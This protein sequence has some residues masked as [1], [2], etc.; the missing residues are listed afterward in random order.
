[1]K[2]Y[3]N[4]C[5]NNSAWACMYRSD[6]NECTRDCKHYYKCDSCDYYLDENMVNEETVS[7]CKTNADYLRN[8]TNEEMAEWLVY[9]VKCTGCNA[10]NCDSKFCVSLMKQW[11]EDFCE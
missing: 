10:E 1:M 5:F 4:N 3:I 9:K 8:M 11:L 7:I 2:C 6:C